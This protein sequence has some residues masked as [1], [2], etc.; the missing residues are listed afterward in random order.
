MAGDLNRSIKIYLDNSD[1]MTSASELETKIGELEKKLL[2]LRA[3]GEGNSKAA[4]KIERELTAQTQKM[5]KYKQEVADTERVLKNLSGAT[6][7]ELLDVKGKIS[8][9]LKKTTRNT[10]EYNSK[11]EMLKRVSKETA[12]VQKEMRVEIGCQASV[13]GRMADGINKYMGIIGTVVVGI[14]GIT[15]KFNQLREARNKLEESKTDVKA[16]T[17]LDDESIEWLTDQAKRLSTTVTEEGIRIRQSADEILEAYKLV[18]SAKPELLA[19]K[20]ALAEVTE[21]T[22]ILASASGMKLTDAVDA[23]T[24]AL[25]QYGDGADQAARYVN[26]LAAGS[27]FGAAAVESQT[28]AIKTSGVAA[29]SAKIPIEQLVGTIETLGEKGIKDEIAGT[30]LKKFFLTLQTGADETNPKIVGLS[31]A[32]ENLR[33]KQMDATAIKKMFGEEGYNVASVLINEADKVEYYTKAVTGTSVALEQAT[34]KSQS[35]TAKMQQAKNKL[36]DLGIEL[37]EKINPSIISVMNQTVNWT[38]K[39]VL[40]ADWISKNT[41]LVVALT[42]TIALYTAVIKLNTYWKTVSNGATLKATIAEKAHLIAVRSST[43]AEYVLAAAKALVTGNIKAATIAM[44]SFLVTLGLNP[45][46]AAGVAITALAIGIYKIWDNS[47]KSAR[48]LKDMNKEIATERAE[49]Y[50]LFDA[51]Q[52]SNAGTKQRKELIDEINSR[53]GKYLENQLTEQSTTEDIAKALEIVNEKLHENIVLKTMQKEK[54]DVTSTTLNKQIDLMD[55]MREKSNLGQFV[56]DAMLRDVKRIT[57][58]GIKNGRSWTKTYDDVIS[59]IDYYYGARGKVD[60]DFWGSLQ[61]YM[62]QTYQLASNLDKISQKYSPLLPKK[63]ANELPEVEVIAPKIKKT[64]ITPG[65]SV[66]QEKKITDAKLKEVDRY[67]ATKKLKLTQDYTEGLRLYDDY[68]TKLQALELEKLNK[69]L[70][71]YKIGSDERKKIEQLILDYKIKLLDKGYQ[72]YLENLQ[73][74][75]DINKKKEKQTKEHY[76]K[77]NELLQGFVKKEMDEKEKA[78]EEE[79]EKKKK[80]FNIMKDF[81]SEAGMILGQALTDTETTFADAMHNILLLTLDT[82]R[83]IAVMAIAERTIKDIGSLGFLGLAKAAGEIALINVA[84]G[85][86]KGLIKKP[87]TSTANAGLNDSTTPQTGQRVVSDSTGWYNGGFTGNGGILEVAGPVHREEYVTPAWQL[88]DPVSMNHILALDA[89]R[90][91]R[92]STNPLPVNGFAN[93]GYNGRSDEENVMVSSNNPEL[94]KVLTQLLMLFSELRAKGMRAYVVYSDIEAAQKTLD[95]SKKIG[96][97]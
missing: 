33:K 97:K 8:S 14:T 83:Q 45:I 57:D 1:A 7:K 76:D 39:L 31:T 49:A 93:G 91:Q 65:L 41:G 51:L 94:L 16:L 63:T 50:T 96:G 61:S 67:I 87:S 54:E 69:Q 71:I 77:L 38:K 52:Q 20:E 88:Q 22:L 47:T 42:S 82:L 64:D 53:Y 75:K 43:A 19:N 10:A 48:A 66:E 27:K 73:K 79:E 28:K 12:L 6:Y 95:K 15:M 37:M 21:Q 32:L 40:M 81:G 62:T 2:D 34:I 59:Y 72:A 3:A 26:V 78:R 24:L 85:A 44:R 56:T 25:N 90:R 89:I 58:E 23:V 68:Q 9:E 80:Q 35:A 92:T 46:I 86:L 4:K 17:G 74:E 30:G 13:W 18:G 55:Q 5:Q 70:A 60:K 84:F 29:A 11:L 36:N